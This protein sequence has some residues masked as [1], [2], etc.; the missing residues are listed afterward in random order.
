M[1][2]GV[3]VSQQTLEVRVEQDGPGASFSNTKAGILQLAEFCRIHQV[4]LVAME[5]SGGYERLAWLLLSAQQIPVAILNPR[6][7]RK[8]AE[9]MGFLEKTDTLD[10]GIIAHYARTRKSKPSSPGSA[11]LQHLRALVTRLRQLTDLQTAQRNQKLLV[12]DPTVQ[13]LGQ[14]LL[15]VLKTQIRSLEKAIAQLIDA[16]PL[17]QQLNESF[18]SIKGVAS[19]T[20]SR[21]MAEMP[22]IGTLSNKQIAKLAGLA[23]L[24]CDSGKMRGKRVIAGGRRP[25]RD[26]LFMVAGVV[27]RFHPDFIAFRQR[28]TKA[29]KAKK[30]VRVALAHKLL[31]RLNAKAR[32]VRL[33]FIQTTPPA[34]P[35]ED[36]IPSRRTRGKAE[37]APRFPRQLAAGFSMS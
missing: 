6:A 26:T 20:V 30:V 22:E 9:S 27:A 13:R 14:Q 17:W 36:S 2:C 35:V 24:A 10:A 33:Q 29:G 37:N 31:T 8:F 1:I 16:D 21:L 19:R 32:E 12:T 7:V 18:R 28:L 23:P 5:A 3:D 34:K 25:I 4:H 11:Q 15:K